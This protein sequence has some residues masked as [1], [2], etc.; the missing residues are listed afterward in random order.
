MLIHNDEV[1]LLISIRRIMITIIIRIMTSTIYGYTERSGLEDWGERRG[2]VSCK[3]R[4]EE[5][6]L[7]GSTITTVNSVTS[8]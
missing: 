8:L 4:R 7:K 5:T 3:R 1:M 2:S 6:R